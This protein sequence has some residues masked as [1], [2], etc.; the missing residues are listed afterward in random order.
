MGFDLVRIEF[1]NNEELVWVD[2]YN[3]LMTILRKVIPGRE[4]RLN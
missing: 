2:Q 1:V 4:T 3:D